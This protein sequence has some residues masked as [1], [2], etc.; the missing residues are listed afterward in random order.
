MHY[1]SHY[2]PEQNRRVGAS[3]EAF[4]VC[5]F[6]Q[7]NKDHLS[8]IGEIVSQGSTT[9]RRLNRQGFHWGCHVLEGP[10][11]WLMSA[12]YVLGTVVAGATPL[13]VAVD[14]ATEE[15][16]AEASW[17]YAV[18]VADSFIYIFAPYWC[19]LLLRVLQRRRLL[20]RIAGRSLVIADVPWVS[21][22]LEAFLSKLFALSYSIASLSVYS[23]NPIDHLVHRQTHRIVR[24]TLLAVGRP[25]ARL[26]VRARTRTYSHLPAAHLQICD[27]RCAI[28][29]VP[30]HIHT[31]CTS[32][33]RDAMCQTPGPRAYG[34]SFCA[35]IA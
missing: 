2:L 29:D 12:A 3:F 21:Q 16:L 17:R 20:H 7:L 4:E 19:A 28:F 11:S 30:S 18:R 14:A 34:P 27:V 8:S 23:A 15:I 10:L 35:D 33:N 13:S 1:C 26:Q 31:C 32:A 25:D 6:A 24:G 22:C 9:R 5:E